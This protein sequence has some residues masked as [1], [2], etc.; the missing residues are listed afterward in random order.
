MSDIV[1]ELREYEPYDCLFT[2]A[3]DEIVFLR[4]TEDSL[5]SQLADATQKLEEARKCPHC[6]DE[7][8]TVQPDRRGEP[9]QVQCEFCYTVP[10]SIFNMR[11]RIDQAIEQGKGGDDVN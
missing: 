6:D 9:E 3:A 10:N 8:F 1:D 7:G 4:A 11:Q 2:K 5:R